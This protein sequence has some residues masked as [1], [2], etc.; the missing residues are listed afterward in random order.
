M[1]Y[2][3]CHEFSIGHPKNPT[4]N[5]LTPWGSEGDS[6]LSLLSPTRTAAHFSSISSALFKVNK[7]GCQSPA[8]HLQ[9]L[10]PTAQAHRKEGWIYISRRQWCSHLG[11]KQVEKRSCFKGLTLRSSCIWIQILLSHLSNKENVWLCCVLNAKGYF[12]VP[13]VKNFKHPWGLECLFGTLL[14]GHLAIIS[15]FS[16][17]KAEI[18]SPIFIFALTTLPKICSTFTWMI[19]R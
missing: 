16:C 12:P 18:S 2:Y 5:I 15:P 11:L 10:C 14:G 9:P 7:F 17:E 1:H 4:I 6:K 19:F 13:G 8:K 3:C